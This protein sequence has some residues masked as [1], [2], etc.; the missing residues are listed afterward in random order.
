MDDLKIDQIRQELLNSDR[1][2]SE[3]APDSSYR[4]QAWGELE[5]RLEE[6]VDNRRNAWLILP[7]LRGV[8]KTTLL[9]QLYRHPAINRATA[10]KAY[11]SLDRLVLLGGSMAG[12]VEVLTNWRRQ[13]YP[14]EPFFIFLDE[15]HHDPKWSLGCKVIF[16]QIPNTFLV[17]TGSSAL[18]L[19][20]SPDGARRAT[21]IDINPLSFEEHISFNQL[22]GGNP[23]PKAAPAALRKDIREALMFSGGAEEAY[24]NLAVCQP[25]INDYYADALADCNRNNPQPGTLDRLMD[26]YIN[27]FGSLPLPPGPAD[28][29]SRD[30]LAKTRDAILQVIDR[31]VVG[32]T[33]KLADSDTPPGN[34]QIQTSTINALPRLLDALAGSDRISLTKL[35]QKLGGTH[36]KTLGVMLEVLT[37]SGLVVEIPARGRLLAKNNLTPKYL[38][39]S[40]AL[41]QALV[42][43]S[44]SRLEDGEGYSRGLRGRLLEDTVLMSLTRLLG[45]RPGRSFIEYDARYGGADFIVYPDQLATKPVIMEVGWSKKTAKQI[46]QTIKRGGRYGLVVTTGS[47]LRAETGPSQAVYV[48]LEYFLLA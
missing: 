6:F 7:G 46:K 23:R 36:P 11:L 39:A 35:A 13:I 31:T 2:V 42:P 17:C 18:S 19:R 5:S 32:D 14:D 33:V 9:T 22:S 48:P 38:F 16:D 25:A 44:S 28:R 20:L 15:V 21:I 47:G 8:G 45:R 29:N 43:L 1:A 12:L 37:V 4:R 24:R 26:N 3:I 34:F 27:R 40:P 41:R 30:G 10:R